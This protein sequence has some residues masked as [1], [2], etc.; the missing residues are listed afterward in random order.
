MIGQNMRDTDKKYDFQSLSE[1]A[2]EIAKM[3]IYNTTFE[4]RKQSIEMGGYSLVVFDFPT[5]ANPFADQDELK[6]RTKADAEK[7]RQMI[8]SGQVTGDK[9]IK[10]AARINSAAG[11]SS[12]SGYY[13]V[14]DN[15]DSVS[16]V[17]GTGIQTFGFLEKY[18]KTLED[19]GLSEISVTQNND[20]FFVDYLYYDKANK[21]IVDQVQ[22][23]KNK[24]RVVQHDN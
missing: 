14:T 3:M 24:V 19:K 7:V 2:D 17:S 8:I 22:S 5:A 23:I 11:R 9:A 6:K 4:V 13:F 21:D 1:S 20:Y 12:L 18:V 10:Q 16:G 15:K